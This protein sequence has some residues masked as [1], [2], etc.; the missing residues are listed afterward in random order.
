MEL[1]KWTCPSALLVTEPFVT[2][3]EMLR[4]AE[5]ISDLRLVTLPHPI[6]D[7]LETDLIDIVRAS[8][9]EIIRQLTSA[10]RA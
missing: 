1:E 2:L 6:N 7:L 3:T 9:P 10:S 4:S 5:G 8:A